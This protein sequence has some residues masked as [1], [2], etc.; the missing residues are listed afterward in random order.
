MVFDE[1]IDAVTVGGCHVDMARQAMKLSLFGCTSTGSVRTILGKPL[2]GLD[3][4]F[5]FVW[6]AIEAT[7]VLAVV[8]RSVSSGI[9]PLEK[10]LWN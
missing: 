4:P 6:F 3:L 10:L 1:C 5:A 8:H 7:E 9:N 2:L